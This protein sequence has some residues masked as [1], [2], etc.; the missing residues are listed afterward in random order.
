MKKT[1]IGLNALLV[2]TLLLTACAPQATP[3][4]T[5]DANQLYTQAA[6]T[7]VAQLTL[8]APPATQTPAATKAPTATNTPLGGALPTLPPLS[9]LPSLA[10]ATKSALNIADKAIYIT[11]SPSDNATVAGGKVFN[12][13]WRL[14][15]TGTT[16]WNNQYV[17][18]FYAAANKIPTAANGYNLTTNVAPNGEVD[19]TVV[20]TAPTS[21][22]LY[23]TQW[24]LTNP[25]GV[26]F[27]RFTLTLNVTAG[28]TTTGT[29]VTEAA[30][31][32]PCSDKNYA[33]GGDDRNVNGTPVVVDV[34]GGQVY[35]S[36]TSDSTT[37]GSFIIDLAGD[38]TDPINVPASSS[39][40][41]W[42]GSPDQDSHTLTVTY[43]GTGAITIKV[44]SINGNHQCY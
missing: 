21:A 2:L 3:E 44:T 19:L 25:E 34:Q 26:N 18:R 11:Q 20:A 10:T 23:D 9:T 35:V 6:Q 36:W 30:P 13:T 32:D 27:A 4:P 14:R 17:Y 15:N 7:V 1:I 5:I 16:T 43:T 37:V 40:S 29:T 8:N 42:V 33:W 22:G 12:I 24:V 31:A 38:A 41:K 28:S 39:G